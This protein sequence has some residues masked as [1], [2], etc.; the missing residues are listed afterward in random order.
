MS[1]VSVLLVAVFLP[2]FPLSMLF[3]G[4]FA[5][6]GNVGLR[7]ALVIGWPAAG[8]A[9]LTFL[10]N[11]PPQWVAYWSVATSLLYGFRTLALR[12]LALWLGHL[13]TSIWAL[14]WL[15]AALGNT[16]TP[17]ALTLFA[18]SVPLALL[19]W[20]T[21]HLER[22]FGAAYAGLLGGLAT[23][24]PRLSVLSVLL[25]L[26]VVGTPLFPGFFALLG[27]VNALLPAMPAIALG[28]LVVWMLWAW[29]GMRI[30]QGLIVG[31]PAKATH[32]DIGLAHAGI[33]GVTAV[34]FAMSGVWVSGSLI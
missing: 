19:I 21:G 29:S 26:A 11:T 24:L 15:P 12:D 27:M 34:L 33:L 5:R 9:L 6:V 23:G 31:R 30:L 14:M 28:V 18:F 25:V 20:L 8:I 4:L 13:A 10:G 17:L 32:V 22:I 1:S 2:L 7:I 3:N 16:G